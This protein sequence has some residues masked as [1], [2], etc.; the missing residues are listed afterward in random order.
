MTETRLFT[1]D[2]AQKN[3]PA[4]KCWF[5]ASPGGLRLLARK[6][7]DQMRSCGPD[8]LELLHDGHPAACVGNLALGYVNAFR[9]HVNIGFFFGSVLPD[10]AGLL[11]GTGRFMRHVKVSTDVPQPEQALQELIAAAYADLKARS[12]DSNSLQSG[13]VTSA[14]DPLLADAIAQTL[15]APPADRARLFARLVGDIESFMAA[16]PEQRPWTCKAYTGTDGSAIFRGGVG[17]SLVI[18]PAGRLWRARSY[19][20]FETTYLPEGNVYVIDTLTPL[21]SQMREYH[22]R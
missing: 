10:P 9:T 18:D 20:D 5:A 3:D 11:V 22:P 16:H 2:G 6:W 21:Y 19:E 17:H 12:A 15:R 4:V 13:V 7:F 8:V 1:L 14:A